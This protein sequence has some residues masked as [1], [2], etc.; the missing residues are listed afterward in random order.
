MPEAFGEG[1]LV[2]LLFP[3]IGMVSGLLAGLFGIG[4]GLVIVPALNLFFAIQPVGI[5]S[6]A[7]MHFAIGSSL[8]V[9]VFTAVSSLL[10]H[11]RRG[12]VLWPAVAR[13]VPGIVI[14]GLLGAA[15]ADAMGNRTLEATFGLLVMAIA[16][17][18]ALG[19]PPRAALPLPAWPGFLGAGTVIGAVSALAG[20]GGGVLT[21]PFLV[22]R[23]VALHTAVGTAAACTM[24]VALA[25]A[26][27]FLFTGVQAG[28]TVPLASGYIYWPAVAGIS[29]A[30][31]LTAPLGARLAHSLPVAKLRR[32]FSLLLVLVGVRMLIG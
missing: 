29:L 22:W 31:V 3:L 13:L 16:L 17:Y 27:G 14:G 6:G 25:G 23:A 28:L 20:I 1:W 26:S 7:R 4:G 11:H 21:V 9:I 32:A 2:Y 19:R 12:A 24:P 5:P 8:A 30:S 15:L 10:A 18:M